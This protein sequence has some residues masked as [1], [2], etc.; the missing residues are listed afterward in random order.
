M[1]SWKPNHHLFLRQLETKYWYLI[2]SQ[3]KIFLVFNFI[4]FTNI[5]SIF[6]VLTFLLY[7]IYLACRNSLCALNKIQQWMKQWKNLILQIF[8]SNINFYL[9]ENFRFGQN[10]SSEKN[11]LSWPTNKYFCPIRK[12]NHNLVCEVLYIFC[13]TEFFDFLSYFFKVYERR[14]PKSLTSCSPFDHLPYASH[15]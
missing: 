13:F 11:F 10:W 15:S 7:S 3:R 12:I 1:Y 5:I 6:F 4:Y 8:Y 2:L 9:K 14:K